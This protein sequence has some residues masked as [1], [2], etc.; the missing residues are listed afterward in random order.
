MNRCSVLLVFANPVHHPSAQPYGLSVVAA[1]LSKR[2]ISSQILLPFMAVDPVQELRNVCADLRPDLIGFSLRNLDTARFHYD[3]DG[4][5]TFL[6][7]LVELINASRVKS[8][9]IALGGSGFS[10]APS[11]ILEFTNADVGFIGSCEYDF[12]EFCFRVLT[13]KLDVK[14]A[15]KNLSSAILPGDVGRVPPP[16]ANLERPGQLEPTAVEYAKLTGGTIPVRTKSG[17][18]M[19][20]SY[21]VVPSIERLILRPWSDIRDELRQIVGL[22]L[23]DRV[24]IADGEFNLPSIDRAVELCRYISSE[25]GTSIKWTCY[26]EAGYVTADLLNAMREAGCV[27][28][29]LTVDSYSRAT[30]IGFIKITKPDAAIKATQLCLDSGIHTDVNLLFGGPNE[31]LESAVSSA[32]IAKEFN[33][34]GVAFSVTIGLRVYP[35]TP[36]SVMVTKERYRKYFRGSDQFSWL[37]MFC[38]DVSAKVLASRIVSVLAP[39]STISY[40][41]TK[42]LENAENADYHRIAVGAN[43]LAKQRFSEAREHFAETVVGSSTSLASKLGMLKAQY[44]L[45][46]LHTE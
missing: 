24:F 30:R 37:G 45:Q 38:S 5:K 34:K 16:V 40:T 46:D 25:F 23:G 31:T 39:S 14:R 12:A 18:S 13:Q 27:G 2:D 8:S 20:C 29:S 36:L 44:G 21:C 1:A 28:I 26:L 19:K 32:R 4:E 41:N 6:P 9:I 17:C 3:D 10:I 33:R 11:Q 42:N 22:G 7:E 43:L 35:N 15:A